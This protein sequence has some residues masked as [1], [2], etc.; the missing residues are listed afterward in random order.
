MAIT[1]VVDAVNNIRPPIH[2][3]R[4]SSVGSASMLAASDNIS[5]SASGTVLTSNSQLSSSDFRGYINPEVGQYSY[6][7]RVDLNSDRVSSVYG[8]A[9][10]FGIIL[11]DI[12]WASSGIS[13]G[14]GVQ[15]INS[16][17]LPPRDIN[18]TSSGEGI[19]PVIYYTSTA[20]GV[21][22]GNVFITYTNSAGISGRT[23]NIDMNTSLQEH[24]LAFISL[25]PGDIGVQ[26]IQT[27]EFD[28]DHLSGTFILALV[29]PLT[30]VTSNVPKTC[31][32]IDS[33]YT[34][35][36]FNNTTFFP[37]TVRVQSGFNFAGSVYISQG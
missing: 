4:N 37:I 29:R 21:G 32:G 14:L 20:I 5:T 34:T 35:K 17:A 6:I 11:C 36:I 15:T 28:V 33:I 27:L 3:F 2:F 18:E 9:R 22:G 30:I 23:G 7:T 1:T 10:G 13:P 26:S 16:I 12:L 25:Q 19:L 8:Q 31:N 24:P